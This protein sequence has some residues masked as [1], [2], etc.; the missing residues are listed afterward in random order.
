[1]TFISYAQNFEDV[2]LWRALQHIEKGFYIDVGA[3]HPDTDS[4]TR[5]LYD[6]E[7][8]GINIEPVPAEF[9][10]LEGAR[11]RDLNLN[12]ALGAAEG[13]ATL[14]VVPGTGLSTLETD[15]LSAIDR[16]GFEHH[17]AQVQIRTLAKIC[18]EHVTGEIH[19]LKID[20]EGGER[21]VL[22]GADF[23]RYRPWIVVI[24][25]TAPMSTVLTHMEWEHILVAAA[26]RF[27][28][29]D[30]LNRFYVAEERW[31]ELAAHFLTPVN[32]FDD[33]I[34]AADTDLAKRINQAEARAA[35]LGERC[36]VLEKQY[37]IT[38]EKSARILAEKY[39][40]V[41]DASRILEEKTQAVRNADMLRV[42]SIQMQQ[43]IADIYKSTSWRATWPIRSLKYL[44]LRLRERQTEKSKTQLLDPE[45][46]W[47]LAHAPGTS[48]NALSSEVALPSSAFR[49]RRSGLKHAVHQFHAGS[50]SADAITNAMLLTRRILRSMGFTSEIFVLHRDPLLADDFRLFEEIPRH[51]NHVLIVRHSMGFD[52]FDELTALPAA[53]ILIYHNITP[54]DLLVG[55]PH[56]QAYSKLGREQLRKLRPL[57]SAALADSEYNAIEL[58]ALGF[59]PVQTCTLLFDTAELRSRAISRSPTGIFTILFVGR[60]IESKGQ[61]DLILAYAQFR[62]KFASPSRLVLVGKCDVESA[63]FKQLEALAYSDKLRSH[64]ILTGLVSD[65]ELD[66][67]YAAA[68]LYVSLSRHEGFGV[69]LVEAMANGVPVLAWPCGAVPYTLGKGAPLLTSREAEDVAVHMVS[70]A[71][72]SELRAS[73]VRKQYTSLA[74]FDLENQKPALTK[75]LAIAGARVPADT[76]A[77]AL[78]KSNAKF[79]VTGHL[80]KSYSL[81][82][83]NRTLAL[84]IEKF[85][86]GSVRVEP[87]QGEKSVLLSQ[88]PSRNQGEIL[89]LAQGAKADCGPVIV[90]SQHYPVHIPTEQGDLLL[91]MFFWEESVIPLETIALLSQNFAGVIAPSRFVAKTLVDSGLSI[92]IFQLEYF[93]DLSSFKRLPLQ[94]KQGD[95]F[96]FLHVSSCF[97][98]KGVDILLQAFARAFRSDDNVRLIIK[99][100]P[101]PHNKAAE[102]VAAFRAQLTDMAEIVVIDEDIEETAILALYAQAD[103]LVL[104]TRGE[105]F[106]LPAAEALAAE[107]PLIVTGYGGHMDF[108]RAHHVRFI[109]YRFVK[110][111]S[112]FAAQH[113]VWVEPDIEDLASAMIEAL[114]NGKRT[115]SRAAA[116]SRFTDSDS[117][118]GPEVEFQI[119]KLASFAIKTLTSTLPQLSIAWVSTWNVR[120]GIAGYSKF[121]IENMPA[122]DRIGQI[123]IL[124]DGRTEAEGGSIPVH[125]CWKL[126]MPDSLTQLLKAISMTD[127]DIV[128]IQHQPGLMTWSML[129]DLLITLTKR[130]KIVT[131]TLHNTLDLLDIESSDRCFVLGALGRIARVI[132]HTVTDLNRLKSLGLVENTVMIPQGAL[133]RGNRPS[134]RSLGPADVP[135]IGCYGFFLPGKGIPQL[136]ESLR[137]VHMQWPTARLRLV[138]ASY[139]GD[140]S[141]SEIQAC[142]DIATISGLQGFIE[143]HTDFLSNEDSL[144]LLA[145]CDVIAL[146]YQ[147]SKEASS[148]SLRT[149]LC[150]GP[151]IMVTPLAIF[152]EADDAVRRF[153]GITSSEIAAGLTELLGDP[154]GREQLNQRAEMWISKHSWASISKRTQGLLLGLVGERDAYK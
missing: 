43:E 136:I 83:V 140:D 151:P 64:V 130:E 74:R 133:V 86:P 129:G 107:I 10:R 45:R 19:F 97:P 55:L 56:L 57:V 123:T 9:R 1:M 49:D 144:E 138:N 104:P 24:E 60:V 18:Q 122:C 141:V 5:A 114:R 30:G 143:W 35:A 108:C 98:R 106:N 40:V 102:Q 11:V 15:P 80:I 142:K 116:L 145:A 101:N 137:E 139:G 135:L 61:L 120:C 34:R 148:A 94:G 12:V 31:H 91:S 16:V 29:Y 50:A 103:A 112:H 4:V 118:F 62:A 36:A 39:Q 150:A 48:A 32:V 20:V 66:A 6:R 68:D 152:D 2:L 77:I 46:T 8:S 117:D 147:S 128:V 72:D 59:A 71:S 100:F 44:F 115:R 105:G 54:T 78:L 13:N 124:A 51:D 37:G 25:A 127:S 58:H 42:A 76:E 126:R 82:A 95:K 79:V 26:Y 154:L 109:D 22:E 14:F 146:P 7:W 84:A 65:E 3:S 28:W 70:L 33:F 96:T 93:P 75:A 153:L 85:R 134:S 131:V 89:R 47:D 132:V 41:H 69:P 23:S 113:S 119:D 87:V 88:M 121:L 38:V 67:H 63:Y 17:E 81:A 53:K 90:I 21:G 73:I 92:P 99:G 111:N 52:G 110:S 125:S 27:T 149:A